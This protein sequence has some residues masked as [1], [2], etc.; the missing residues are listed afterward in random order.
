MPPTPNALTPPLPCS[1]LRGPTPRDA[2]L[3]GLP[4]LWFPASTPLVSFW[5]SAPQ[6]SVP[7][8]PR[9]LVVSQD[10]EV[11]PSVCV[12]VDCASSSLKEIAFSGT[13]PISDRLTGPGGAPWAVS[14]PHPHLADGPENC[15]PTSRSRQRMYMDPW[16]LT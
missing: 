12:G 14:H 3:G 16:K 8:P 11:R 7:P 1:A 4:R 2:E 10:D 6:E 15:V 9:T 5:H 13:L